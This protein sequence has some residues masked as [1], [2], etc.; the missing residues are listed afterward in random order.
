MKERLTLDELLRVIEGLGPPL[1]P[2]YLAVRGDVA[3]RIEDEFG[4]FRPD[5]GQTI[6]AAVHVEV[7]KAQLFPVW[8]FEDLKLFRSYLAGEVTEANLVEMASAEMSKLVR[9]GSTETKSGG[10]VGTQ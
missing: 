9:E 4:P 7:K 2:T 1:K 5:G 3:A 6:P 10:T 8:K